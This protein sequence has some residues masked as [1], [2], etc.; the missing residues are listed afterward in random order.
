MVLQGTIANSLFSARP[1][2]PSRLA[3]RE[4]FKTQEEI[5]EF[6]EAQGTQEGQ[7]SQKG[8]RKEEEEGSKVRQE[9]LDDEWPESIFHHEGSQTASYPVSV[10]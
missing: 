9:E 1:A 7:G 10:Q 5:E 3:R 4:L 6:F 8:Q 2:P